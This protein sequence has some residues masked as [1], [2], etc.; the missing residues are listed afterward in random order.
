MNL[1]HLCTSNVTRC[2]VVLMEAFLRCD[3]QCVG[4]ET[5]IFP[6]RTQLTQPSQLAHRRSRA[7]HCLAQLLPCD[8]RYDVRF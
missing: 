6:K 8:M 1:M 2:Y 3:P 5:R 7:C 4:L